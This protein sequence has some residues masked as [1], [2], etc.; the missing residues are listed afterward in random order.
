[1][2][3]G[4]GGK[5]SLLFVYG[6]LIPGLEP[7]GMSHIVRQFTMLGPATIRGRLYD[8]GPYPGV[9][10]DGSPLVIRGQLVELPSQQ[11]L[12]ELDRYEGCPLPDSSEGLFR[13][14]RT[15]AICESGEAAECWLYVYNRE[16]NGAKLVESGC[17]LTH[18]QPTKI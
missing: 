6:T 10:I 5:R 17:W 9:V 7:R 8:L 12:D 14:V 2:T 18:R 11:L 13:R 4:A 1:M 3:D 16:L 15:A